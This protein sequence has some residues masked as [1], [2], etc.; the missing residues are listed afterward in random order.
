MKS[1]QPMI[2]RL[3]KSQLIFSALLD[4]SYKVS[5]AKRKT[6]ITTRNYISAQFFVVVAFQWTPSLEI[7][8]ELVWIAAN[9]KHDSRHRRSRLGIKFEAK[10]TKKQ[11][12][13]NMKSK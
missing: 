11:R 1:W 10:E 3:G 6:A 5:M 9:T 2:F 13:D 7:E 12:D 4:V 8:V